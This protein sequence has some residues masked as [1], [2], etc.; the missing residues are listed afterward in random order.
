ML[1]LRSNLFSSDLF[2]DF[3]LD[4]DAF[5]LEEAESSSSSFVGFTLAR[6][7]PEI[8]EFDTL[9]DVLDEVEIGL[10]VDGLADFSGGSFLM[11]FSK[12]LSRLSGC[13]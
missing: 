11:I 4:E 10:E 3:E 12:Q 9:D 7:V 1:V 5:E 6:D 8:F 2:D 13:C